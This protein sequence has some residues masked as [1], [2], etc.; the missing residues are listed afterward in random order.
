MVGGTQAV[1]VGE[2]TTATTEF[3]ALDHRLLP[4]ACQLRRQDGDGPVSERSAMVDAVT[5]PSSPPI[6]VR[7]SSKP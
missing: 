2:T 6:P 5:T 7:R 1:G 4:A 3:H